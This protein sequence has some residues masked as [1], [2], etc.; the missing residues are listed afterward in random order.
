LVSLLLS[1]G[2]VVG[3]A[4]SS[5]AAPVPVN[6][7]NGLSY[8]DYLTG[9]LSYPAVE[10]A[11]RFI[12][13]Q[14]KLAERPAAQEA[15]KA[16]YGFAGC[17][18]PP[19]RE[20]G[21]TRQF[22]VSQ[23][24]AGN[25]QIDA[26][27]AA[28]SRHGYLWVQREFYAPAPTGAPEGGFVT[29]AE[30]EAALEDWE[31]IYTIDRKYF[32]KEPSPDTPAQNLAPGLPS[33][34]R[35]ADCDKHI[36]ILN[37]P[38]DAP[39][40]NQSTGYVAG[41]YS[42]EH[43]YPNGDGEHESPFSN[44]TEMF[45]M[46]SAFLDVGDDT[47][48]GVLAHEFFHMIQFSNDYNE[49]TWVNEGM[50]DIAAI[51]NGFGDI[52]EG[53]ISAYSEQPDN[54][55][56]DWGSELADYGQ[57]VL[58]FDYLF[59]HYGERDNP[60]TEDNEAYL[61]MANLLTK[62]VPDGA[63]GVTKV[64]RARP[65][66]VVSKLPSYYAA[67]GFKKVFK[68]YLVANYLDAPDLADGQFGY[69]NRDVK[70]AAAGTGDAS[71]E[72]ATVHPYAGEYYEFAADQEGVID[73]TVADPV[74]LIPANE[75]QPKPANGKF[76]WSSR[77]DELLTWLE[78]GADLR[79]AKAPQ[80]K[81]KHWY[82][83]EED[84][85]Y[86]YVRVSTDGGKTYDFLTTTEC[87]G[88]ATDPN[89]NNRA[90]LESGGITGNSEGWQSCTLDL[91]EYAGK[92]V[93]IR[94]EYETDQAVTEPGYVVDNVKLVDGKRKIW[95]TKKFERTNNGF[96]FGGSGLVKWRRLR[97]LAKN[98]PFIQLVRL[99][100]NNVKRKV[101]T[102]RAFLSGDV[103]KLRNKG[104]VAGDKTVVIFTS[105]TPIATYPFAYSYKVTR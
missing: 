38:I 48:A 43:E 102:R 22:W 50:A 47:Y 26:V 25:I 95:R 30:A 13:R 85:D 70:V 35:D 92:K 28:K 20:V 67:A 72:D 90:A 12:A 97:P 89:G 80:L 21:D 76:A 31:R 71:A 34:W 5:G 60:D 7:A 75:G 99:S 10:Q 51:V 49:E 24:Q 88:R 101:Y 15:P 45:F 100:G 2:L 83:I 1:V 29:Q 44:E 64:I 42:S 84:W 96:T 103:L 74:A 27:L 63:A 58:F 11:D 8:S 94:Y 6:A 86:A 9:H 59:N 81:F 69:A 4:A 77:A 68:D 54:H 19:E 32:G 62:T 87:G 37:F 93:L 65:S 105:V 16:D 18:P 52:V 39:G 78:R 14:E 53:H 56:F 46:N 40:A 82:Q 17:T 57:A 61:A 23:S 66:S 98:K 3:L 33:N 41:Y 55:L 104:T 79:K 36:S 91:A 73:M